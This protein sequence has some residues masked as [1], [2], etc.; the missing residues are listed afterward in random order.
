VRAIPREWRNND[1]NGF[2]ACTAA[3]AARHTAQ[4]KGDPL[5][6]RAPGNP[7][8]AAG[9]RPVDDLL[10]VH[11]VDGVDLGPAAGRPVTNRTAIGVTTR[12]EAPPVGGAFLLPPEGVQSV[13]SVRT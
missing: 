7:R 2:S 10:A 12:V 1:G 8:P 3:R 11:P 13:P 9:D 5:G 4:S 6:L